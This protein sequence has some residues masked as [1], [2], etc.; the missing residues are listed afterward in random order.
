M[1]VAKEVM[2][3]LFFSGPENATMTM[4]EYYYTKKPATGVAG[5]V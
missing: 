5:M 4:W 2:L 1:L 3:N